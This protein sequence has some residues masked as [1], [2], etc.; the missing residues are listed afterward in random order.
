MQFQSLSFVF[1]F[2]PLTL[3]GYILLRKTRFA[4]LFMLL[5]SLFFYAVGALWYL[6]PFFITALLD[7]FIGQRI[8]DSD[9]NVYRRRLLIV[10][11]VANLGVLS[12]FKYTGWLTTGLSGLLADFGIP[13]RRSCWRCRPR[14]PSIRFSR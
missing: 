7:F 5:A 12:L 14:S 2:L 3:L 11:V 4:N 1:G 9:R 10:S 6:V 8:Q 13:F